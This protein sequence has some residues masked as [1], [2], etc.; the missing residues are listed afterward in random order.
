MALLLALQKIPREELQEAIE[1]ITGKKYVEDVQTAINE[2]Y[3]RRLGRYIT[4]EEISTY[5]VR[6]KTNE[7]KEGFLIKIGR[8]LGVIS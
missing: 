3:G 2:I 1:E 5:V 4:T 7:V 6:L 8:F